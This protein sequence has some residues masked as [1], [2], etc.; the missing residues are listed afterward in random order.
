MEKNYH[1]EPLVQKLG[2]LKRKVQDMG[3]L[4]DVLTR[5]AESDTTKDPSP[6]D[7]QTGKGKKNNGGKGNQQNN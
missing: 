5:Y 2:W 1:F 3:E 7:D 4:M 6:D